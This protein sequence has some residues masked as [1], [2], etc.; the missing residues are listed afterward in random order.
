MTSPC[1]RHRMINLLAVL[2]RP[3]KN[4]LRHLRL[5]QIG[6]TLRGRVYVAGDVRLGHGS[7]LE[8]GCRLI[9]D[10]C[11]VIGENFY[12][13]AYCHML[14]D[15]RIGND[16]ML[17][18]KVT[19]WARDHGMRKD[20]LMRLQS[21]E[22]APITI[23]DDV[24]IGAGAIVLRGVQIGHGAVVGAGSVVTKNVPDWAVVAGVPAKII[25]YREESSNSR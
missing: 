10:P 25:K 14:G 3:L 7:V 19:I 16:V 15:I 6:V 18:P 4:W 21:H 9:G 20:V 1:S 11:L 12:A 22:A 23:G 17:G 24:W 5:W 2:A 8:E 13:N